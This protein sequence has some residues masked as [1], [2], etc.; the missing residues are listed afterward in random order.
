MCARGC[1]LIVRTMRV[2]GPDSHI[3]ELPYAEGAC[4]TD[5]ATAGRIAL[6][7]DRRAAGG[8]NVVMVCDP[9]S[10]GG[11]LMLECSDSAFGFRWRQCSGFGGHG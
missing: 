6:G 4:A 9:F 3:P 8:D 7:Q 1:R 10:G 5:E 11:A 2:T